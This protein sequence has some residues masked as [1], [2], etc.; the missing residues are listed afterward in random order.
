MCRVKAHIQGPHGASAGQGAQR[1][2]QPEPRRRAVADNELVSEARFDL[3]EQDSNEGTLRL[4][5]TGT[6]DAAAA[7]R[8]KQRL[9]EL[10]IL[11]RP[12]TLDLS[13][14]DA[15][16]TEGVEVLVEAHADARIKG[17]AFVI[18]PTLSPGVASVLRLAHLERLVEGEH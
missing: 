15:I 3:R 2:R 14:L 11:G 16:D 17:W 10:R 1:I 18:D 13:G 5:P 12:V 4:M 8:L 7:P 9:H 6:L